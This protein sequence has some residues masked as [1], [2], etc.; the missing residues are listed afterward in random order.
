MLNL[1]K[2]EL[3]IKLEK[4]LINLKNK[5][6]KLVYIDEAIIH[7]VNGGKVRR[8]MD[9]SILELV[10]QISI[11]EKKRKIFENKWINTWLY[12]NNGKK[13]TNPNIS[14]EDLLSPLEVFEREGFNRYKLWE[15]A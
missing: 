1:K 2:E 7:Y 10:N 6:N 5:N 11:V 8:Y 12:Y 4:K 15:V 14:S 13:T 9:S 3:L